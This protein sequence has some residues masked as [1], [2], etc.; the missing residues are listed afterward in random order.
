MVVAQTLAAALDAAEAVKVDYE[1]LPGMFHSE[2]A[3]MPGAWRARGLGRGGA[4]RA[5]RG[6]RPLRGKLHYTFYAGT[7][8]STPIT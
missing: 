5:A 1:V 3:L 4:A 8:D 2:A 7:W 6:A